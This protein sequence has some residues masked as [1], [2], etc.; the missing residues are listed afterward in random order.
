METGNKLL[1]ND[2]WQLSLLQETEILAIPLHPPTSEWIL[3]LFSSHHF[4]TLNLCISVKACLC[5]AEAILY[6]IFNG[7]LCCKCLFYLPICF[8]FLF[9]SCTF[10]WCFYRLIHFTHFR[11]FLLPPSFHQIFNRSLWHARNHWKEA[12]LVFSTMC[13]QLLAL[14]TWWL[15]A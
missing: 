7:L 3:I 12:G 5:N 14:Y 13:P 1:C 4:S 6:S 9:L 10:Y 11:E 8:F 15:E 2:L